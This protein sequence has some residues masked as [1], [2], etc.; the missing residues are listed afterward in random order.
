VVLFSPPPTAILAATDA[1][2]E[3]SE[4]L[5]VAIDTNIEGNSDSAVG[6][7]DPCTELAA[8]GDSFTFDL[9]VKNVS[10]ADLIAGFQV[11]IDYDPLVI[12]I[13]NII[14][15]DAAGS[16]APA[17]VTILS[18]IASSGGY[19]FLHLSED[20]PDVDGSLTVSAIDGTDTPLPPDNSEAG[21]GVLAR[22]T[23]EAVGTGTSDLII[24]GPLGGVD[25]NSDKI[26]N[27]GSGGGRELH[28]GLLI[29]GRVSVGE[30]CVAP[31]S[32]TVIVPSETPDSGT[33]TPTATP[34]QT[35]PADGTPSPVQPNGGGEV[36]DDGGSNTLLVI[37]I[38]AGVWVVAGLISA[39][40]YTLRRRR[41]G[42]APTE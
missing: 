6:P 1:L 27:A 12:R 4:P 40:W 22:V 15:A 19:E 3:T 20:P 38:I 25:G 41:R 5:T 11:D 13:T 37:G 16:E 29:S 39:A 8:V 31:P 17:N 14:D 36:S 33:E 26:I 30:P 10:E 42:G 7:I 32:P 9:V 23:A 2:Q 28:V 34:G 35:I 21:D 24:P 18:R